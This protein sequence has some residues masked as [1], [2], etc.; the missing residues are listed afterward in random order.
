[1][2]FI[3]CDSEH[4][5]YHDFRFF[6]R[7]RETKS[8]TSGENQPG[9][10]KWKCNVKTG[11]NWPF[12][13]SNM[14]FQHRIKTGKFTKWKHNNGVAPAIDDKDWIK[15]FEEMTGSMVVPNQT[16]SKISSNFMAT[17]LIPQTT[18]GPTENWVPFKK[19]TSNDW[20]VLFGIASLPIQSTEP[21]I[22]T[23]MFFYWKY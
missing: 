1:M 19:K 9:V 8:E 13:T 21:D 2:Y 15:L 14:K 16:H 17:H 6:T 22:C 10:T 4:G 11:P 3:I 7:N 5:S 23:Y 20:D 12:S 18:D